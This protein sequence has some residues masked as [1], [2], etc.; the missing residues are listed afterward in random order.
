MGEATRPTFNPASGD[1][2]A[3]T[4]LLWSRYARGN[5]EEHGNGLIRTEALRIMKCNA[6]PSHSE[7]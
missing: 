5:H 7:S 2:F 3:F 6:E 4:I 1:F